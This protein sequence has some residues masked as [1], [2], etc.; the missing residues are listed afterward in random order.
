MVCHLRQ[1]HRL[2]VLKNIVLR[3]IFG[4]KRDEV[5][6]E[7]RRLNNKEL[8]DLYSSPNITWVMKARRMRRMGHVTYMGDRGAY[9][10][11]VGKPEGKRPLGKP[12]HR[13]KDNIKIDIQEVGLGNVLE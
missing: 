8:Y 7:W 2:R 9:R 6:G 12:R 11:L 3:K 4:S 5:L 1:E 10:V 13:R